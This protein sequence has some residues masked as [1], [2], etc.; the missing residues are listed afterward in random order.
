MKCIKEKTCYAHFKQFQAAEDSVVG[1]RTR[2]RTRILST[3][4]FG[5]QNL[6][7]KKVG[8]ISY[9]SIFFCFVFLPPSVYS[10]STKVAEC[11]RQTPV[12]NSELTR[13]AC[14]FFYC[15][16]VFMRTQHASIAKYLSPTSILVHLCLQ[17][18]VTARNR[19]HIHK[20]ETYPYC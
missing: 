11:F 20:T 18:G 1:S 2:G 19:K 6:K 10:G 12:Y 3:F 17:Q 16:G 14:I 13:Y 5:L 9:C 7:K 15:N 4:A 8:R